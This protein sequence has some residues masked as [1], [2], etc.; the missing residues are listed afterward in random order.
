M[1]GIQMVEV[2]LEST[3]ELARVKL[4][5]VFKVPSHELSDDPFKRKDG[6]TSRGG[7][8]KK[9]ESSRQRSRSRSREK[10]KKDRK[11]SR[12]RSRGRDKEEGSKSQKKAADAAPSSTRADPSGNDWLASRIRVRVVT[13][14]AV[15]G[16]KQS[17]YRRTGVVIDV[18]RANE[19]TVKM[20]SG[21]VLE[22]ELRSI[23]P[24]YCTAMSSQL[25]LCL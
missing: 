10:K 12:S 24:V 11:R 13:E 9:E 7:R 19:A 14:K 20:D 2:E 5:E 18:P 1:G 21:E 4:T 25:M 17:F 3:G 15:G 8:D 22:G 16:Y 23:R 6:S